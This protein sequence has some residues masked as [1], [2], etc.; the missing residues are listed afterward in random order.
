M[1]KGTVTDAP[2]VMLIGISTG[3]GMAARAESENA[4]TKIVASSHALIGLTSSS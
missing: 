2:G 3:G 1:L 4:P